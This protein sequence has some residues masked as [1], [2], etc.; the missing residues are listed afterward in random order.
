MTR[1][2]NIHRVKDVGTQLPVG[3]IVTETIAK[4]LKLLPR[5]DLCSWDEVRISLNRI[6]AATDE[7]NRAK[8]ALDA[9]AHAFVFIVNA[10]EEPLQ[11]PE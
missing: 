5:T 8:H 7:L 4:H 1:T 11:V 3:Y 9:A 10:T 6:G 2:F